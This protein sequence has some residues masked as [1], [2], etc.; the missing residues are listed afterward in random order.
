MTTSQIVF[1]TGE[2]VSGKGLW[3]R[4]QMQ[5]APDGPQALSIIKQ[6]HQALLK[7]FPRIVWVTIQWFVNLRAELVK[8]LFMRSIS[9]ALGAALSGFRSA[10]VLLIPCRNN[11]TVRDLIK[12]RCAAEDFFIRL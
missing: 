11:L 5:L 9:L 1:K 2:L 12:D 6:R 3:F 4:H 8:R 10:L 7:V